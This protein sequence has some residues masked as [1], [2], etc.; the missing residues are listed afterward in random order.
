[1]NW[2]VKKIRKGLVDKVLRKFGTSAAKQRIWDEEFRSGS[3]ERIDHT[4]NDPIYL[5]L[6]RYCKR[7][8]ILDLGCGA[9]N[10]GNELD[11]SQYNRYDGVDVSQEA[12]ERAIERS[13]KS[14]RVGKNSYFVGDMATFVP[15]KQYSVILLRESLYYLPVFK[16]SK[17]L[18]RLSNCLNKDG[19]LIV[20]MHDRNRYSS[21]IGIIRNEFN[22]CEEVFPKGESSIILV[23]R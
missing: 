14:G 5:S 13:K 17:I 2:I 1:M 6:A 23:F 4:E 16:I 8:N 19:Y 20:R 18:R 9:G 7:G 21:I 22:V 15:Q 10:T 3:W 11:V 12:V